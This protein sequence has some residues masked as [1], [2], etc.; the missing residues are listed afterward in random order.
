MIDLNNMKIQKV[1]NPC[2]HTLA[3]VTSEAIYTGRKDHIGASGDYHNIADMIR[4]CMEGDDKTTNLFL[5][6]IK[7]YTYDLIKYN[8]PFVEIVAKK[9][10]EVETL[11]YAE[12]I[13][14][15]ADRF[16]LSDD[17]LTHYKIKN[18]SAA[19]FGIKK[20]PGI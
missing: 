11:S 7:S 6:F 4:S 12:F 13:K 5:K 2:F 16:K 20:K 15:N 9:L 3:G 8:W 18:G 17:A 1:F 14:V 10:T 19:D